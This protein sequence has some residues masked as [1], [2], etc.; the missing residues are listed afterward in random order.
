[1]VGGA[2]RTGSGERGGRI[3]QFLAVFL[4]YSAIV[5]M[6][7]PEVWQAIVAG[8]REGRQART[9]VETPKG[10][11]AKSDPAPKAGV[12]SAA[13]PSRT[14]A[15]APNPAAGAEAK[16][17]PVAPAAEGRPADPA[18]RPRPR[19]RLGLLGAMLLAMLMLVGL[20]Y[21]TP[22][23]FGMNAPIS[24]LIFACGLWQAWVM[25]RG[26]ELPVTG[27]YRIRAPGKA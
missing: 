24:A 9:Q 14:D 18:A 16:A 2:V 13:N 8:S 11:V 17:R 7:L 12:K 21:S 5:G 20:I 27:P 15:D 26:R 3:Y 1:M 22:V 6:F 4:T 25:T 10:E 19:S 23:V